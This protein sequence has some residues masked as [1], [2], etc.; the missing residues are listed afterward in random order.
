[1]PKN[2]RN[3]FWTCILMLQILVD[4]WRCID[5]SHVFNLFFFV[6][7]CGCNL[8]IVRQRNQK[9][10]W[11]PCILKNVKIMRPEWQM[12]AHG[13]LLVC[14]LI[15]AYLLGFMKNCC[16][17]NFNGIGPA[18]KN[19]G[20]NDSQ[21]QRTFEES[22]QMTTVSPR[23]GF[24]Q[25]NIPLRNLDK[26]QMWINIP[27]KN[28]DKWQ[29]FV[30]SQ[31]SPDQHT[32]EESWQIDSTYSQNHKSIARPGPICMS[33]LWLVGLVITPRPGYKLFLEGTRSKIS[34][35]GPIRKLLD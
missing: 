18:P 22:W 23:V 1:M 19:S 13:R 28:R 24:L 15:A 10:G 29:T 26:W 12:C 25:I 20:N 33:S 11:K 35:P 32:F 8:M 2:V 31:G 9:P 5:E 14:G 17:P 7:N 30:L 4:I 3:I 6:W 34:C 16:L 21:N 27:S